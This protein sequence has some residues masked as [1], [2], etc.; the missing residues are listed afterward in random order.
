MSKACA[1]WEQILL[2]YPTDLMAVKFV[3]DGY[4][5]SGDMVN[6][7]NAVDRVINKWSPDLPCASYLYG[8]LAFG[9]EEL[10]HYKA[11]EVA[12]RRALDANKHDAW[13]SHAIA[14]C[15]EMK[16]DFDGGIKFMESTNEDWRVSSSI[17]YW[18]SKVL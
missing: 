16:S 15:F 18:K 17:V 10:E 1:E 13:A 3:T 12:A 4:F 7:M 6:K 8:M 2:D 5:F 11:A 9:L 14:H